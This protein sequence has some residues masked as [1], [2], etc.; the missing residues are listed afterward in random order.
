MTQMA[1]RCGSIQTMSVCAS[2]NQTTTGST[3]RFV[4]DGPRLLVARAPLRVRAVATLFASRRGCSVCAVRGAPVLSI[5]GSTLVL[6]ALRLK[7]EK[8]TAR[9]VDA[10]GA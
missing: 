8:V 7:R 4:R 6:N 9:G 2:T 10:I 5:S 3:C 1:R